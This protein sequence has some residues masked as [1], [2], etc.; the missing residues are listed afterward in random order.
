MRY[1]IGDIVRER[2][3]L[4]PDKEYNGM[5]FDMG[6]IQYFGQKLKVSH[7]TDGVY[8]LEDEY[9]DE[10][11]YYWTDDM[12]YADAGECICETLL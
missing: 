3:N 1:K 10:T 7:I 4:I 11:Y 5:R 2:P 12:L 6:M 8:L 9:G